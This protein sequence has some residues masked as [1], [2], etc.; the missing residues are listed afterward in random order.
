MTVTPFRISR[1][2]Y[3]KMHRCPGWAG[4]G[5]RYA[6]RDRCAGTGYVGSPRRGSR[7]IYEGKLWRLRVN[8]CTACGVWVLPWAVRYLDPGWWGYRAARKIED[9]RA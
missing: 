7:I 6:K 9:W 5:M 1:P 8:R 4:G 2:C 3:S